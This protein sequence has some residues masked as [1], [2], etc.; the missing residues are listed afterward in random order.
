MVAIALVLAAAT[1]W[2]VAVRFFWRAGAW[3]PYYV[4][5]SAGCALLIVVVARMLPF[6]GWL[7]WLTAEGVHHTAFLIGVDTTTA[8]LHPGSL[9]VVGFTAGNQW[10]NM[11]IGLECSGLL[12]SAALCGLIAFFPANGPARR[13]RILLIALAA[14][15]VANIVRVLVIVGVVAYVGQDYLEFAHVVLG[16][17]VFFAMAVGIY[18]FAITR[19]TLQLVG[20]RL[21]GGEA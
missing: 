6:E 10:T 16:R 5:G 13:S 7:Q 14:T 9:L 1:A 2:A 8:H 15:F 19:P 20:Q 3:L 11:T 18:W 4:L 21:R 17:V 12:E